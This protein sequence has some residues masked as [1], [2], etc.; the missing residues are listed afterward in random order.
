MHLQY[1]GYTQ[2]VVVST[3]RQQTP[4]ET[5][6][7]AIQVFQSFK[8]QLQCPKKTGNLTVPQQ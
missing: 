1:S 3:S 4:E 5:K 7:N 6:E 8:I 2:E